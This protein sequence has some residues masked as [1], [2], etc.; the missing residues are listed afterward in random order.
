M[1]RILCLEILLLRW[2][3]PSPEMKFPPWFRI[4][5][6]WRQPNQETG[7]Q[8]FITRAVN[9]WVLWQAARFQSSFPTQWEQLSA[10][11]RRIL[12]AW[13]AF[14]ATSCK[15]SNYKKDGHPLVDGHSY[16][17]STHWCLSKHRFQ[18]QWSCRFKLKCHAFLVQ[19]P[20]VWTSTEIQQMHNLSNVLYAF[21][22]LPAFEFK[23]GLITTACFLLLALLSSLLTPLPF[24]SFFQPGHSTTLSCSAY[25]GHTLFQ[26]STVFPLSLP[27]TP[28][29]LLRHPLGYC[30]D[31]QLASTSHCHP[32]QSWQSRGARTISQRALSSLTRDTQWP[33]LTPCFSL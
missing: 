26:F 14:H 32:S 28:P 5:P 15:R 22:T 21:S 33:S 17:G 2:T 12:Q 24:S 30:A 7:Q 20:L 25:N 4:N 6:S 8:I 29:L 3:L 23:F 11:F 13:L 1:P 10:K 16:N 19:D 18:W 9:K 27:T 31:L